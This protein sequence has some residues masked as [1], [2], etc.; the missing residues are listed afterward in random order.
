MLWHY[1]TVHCLNSIIED[2]HIR[3]ATKGVL[4]TELAIAWFSTEEFWE[5]TVEKL[6]LP[7]NSDIPQVLDMKAMLEHDI[8][9]CRIGLEES[10]APH[11]W[12]D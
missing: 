5:P 10:S 11:H 3:C 7:G 9:L 12:E 2:G 4:A 1:T 6:W 8:L